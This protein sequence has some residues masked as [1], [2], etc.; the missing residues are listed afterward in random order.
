MKPKAGARE[1]GSQPVDGLASVGGV[2]RGVD[3][4]DEV[5]HRG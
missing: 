2:E 1:L 4:V 5:E 3:P